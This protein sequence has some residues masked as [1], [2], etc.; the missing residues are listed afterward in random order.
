MGYLG[1]DEYDDKVHKTPVCI[2]EYAHN[3]I[4]NDKSYRIIIIY[5]L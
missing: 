5:Q 2:E 4:L 1:G 3:F